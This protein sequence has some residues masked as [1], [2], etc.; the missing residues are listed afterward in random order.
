MQKIIGTFGSSDHKLEPQYIYI[1]KSIYIYIHAYWLNTC[2]FVVKLKEAHV[3]PYAY[4]LPISVCP[5]AINLTLRLMLTLNPVCTLTWVTLITTGLFYFKICIKLVYIHHRLSKSTFYILWLG[6]VY[7]L[8]F[9]S[10]YNIAI[11][12]MISQFPASRR[13]IYISLL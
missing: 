6:L 1:A 10:I 11:S 9:L 4:C 3:W 2:F 5:S 13:S 8:V 7:W 12:S